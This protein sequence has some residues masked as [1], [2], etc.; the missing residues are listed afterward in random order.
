MISTPLSKRQRFSRSPR[1][2]DRFDNGGAAH[3]PYLP[4]LAMAYDDPFDPSDLPDSVSGRSFFCP[5]AVSPSTEI[6]GCHI[7]QIADLPPAVLQL[8]WQQADIYRDLVASKTR[9]RVLDGLI[10]ATLF[11]EPSTRTR[12]SFEAAMLRLGGQVIS[13]PD[14]GGTSSAI[15]GESIADSIR[16]VCGYSDLIVQR[17]PAI[18][19]AHQAAAAANDYAVPVINAGD[20]A[21]EHP[22]QAILD[23]YTIRDERGTLDGL[24]IVLAGDLKHGRT[25]HSLLRALVGWDVKITLV[26][27]RELAMPRAV[28]DSLPRHMRLEE[29]ENLHQAT[30]TADVLYMTR[31]QKERFSDPTQYEALKDQYVVDSRFMA[32][33]PNL[34]LLHPLPRVNEISAEVDTLPNA[35][36]FR[37]AQNGLYV[38]MA[39]LALVAGRA[40][41][42]SQN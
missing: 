16:V 11:Y 36:Y 24:H 31:L 5:Y 19:S 22:T 9:L 23:L 20:G 13:T 35:A 15:K 17:H 1:R 39:L 21:G 26:A 6:S 30:S 37:Q 29:T 40:V 18:G 34:T 7:L 8:I 32:E 3:L 2:R 14:G 38:R 25:V 42:R 33:R 27:P 41:R 12:L 4:P 28:I 10:L